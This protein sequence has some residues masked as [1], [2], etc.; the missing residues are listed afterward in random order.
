M[1]Y[2][3]PIEDT[4]YNEKG[5]RGL[6]LVAVTKEALMGTIFPDYRVEGAW[7][8]NQGFVTLAEDY[9]K[10]DI[11][12]NGFKAEFLLPSFGFLALCNVPS[13][14]GYTGEKK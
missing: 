2:Q 12:Y 9:I 11:S 7:S 1:I 14:N 3:H 5:G 8:V 6:V 10:H 13:V 4:I